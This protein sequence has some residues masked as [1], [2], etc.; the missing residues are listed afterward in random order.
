MTYLFEKIPEDQFILVADG[1][2]HRQ[3][4]L[5]EKIASEHPTPFVENAIFLPESGSTIFFE[6]W[7]Q[8]YKRHGE[9]AFFR[10]TPELIGSVLTDPLFSKQF[11][12][13]S[14]KEMI[15]FHYPHISP[16][17]KFSNW[18]GD[19]YAENKMIR[20]WLK[21]NAKDWP[22]FSNWKE[23]LGTICR[24]DEIFN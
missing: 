24:Y 17:P 6:R 15:Q 12:Y 3:G 9:F 23:S 20:G 4:K 21:K 14:T 11:P 8:K 10:S 16:R 18:L 22:E 5:Y 13:S 19:A 1:D 2:L 7:N